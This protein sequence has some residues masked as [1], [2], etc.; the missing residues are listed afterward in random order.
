MNE[1]SRKYSSI[2]LLRENE[3]RVVEKSLCMLFLCWWKLEK[4]QVQTSRCLE[5]LQSVEAYNLEWVAFVL[6]GLTKQA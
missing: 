1:R 2:F 3:V 6:S 5:A 4:G